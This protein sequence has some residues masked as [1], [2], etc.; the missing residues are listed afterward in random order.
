MPPADVTYSIADA[1][2]GPFSLNST[3]G[4]L[5]VTADLDYDSD[6]IPIFYSF[7]VNCSTSPNHTDTAVVEI[8]VEPV[9]DN[10]PALVST[11]SS[12][13]VQLIEDAPI[14][15]IIVVNNV[16]QGIPG[17]EIVDEDKGI[18]GVLT[19]LLSGG[20]G[21]FRIEPTTG[22]VFLQATIDVDTSTTG[23]LTFDMG[24]IACDLVS[25]MMPDTCPKVEVKVIG[26]PTNDHP[27]VFSQSV[28]DTFNVT[29]PEG[30]PI[31]API[32][33]VHCTDADRHTFGILQGIELWS[34]NT[35]IQQ[36]VR[37]DIN[38]STI[39]NATVILNATLDY[40]TMEAFNITLRCFDSGND[41]DFATVVVNI[42]P[43]NDNMPRFQSLHY[44]FSVDRINLPNRESI[45]TV[46]AIDLDKGHGGTLSYSLESSPY[47][48]ID[49]NG[50]ITLVDYI[51]AMEGDSFELFVEVSDGEFSDNATVTISVT[52]PLSVLDII[53]IEA[54][55]ICFI[56]L[57]CCFICCCCWCYSRYG[58]R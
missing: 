50:T 6:T 34:A 3:T 26:V 51:L 55:F 29:Y 24:I 9:N 48:E 11:P 8:S 38:D 44:N 2:P 46:E 32:A 12:V 58:K 31:N 45:G 7:T 33:E 40:E 42:E 18:D 37:V 47:F 53:I 17:Y 5:S 39:T 27:P 28:Y 54:G 21:Y 22:T 43:V 23:I 56:V 41:E 20:D 52:G 14:G 36:I 35:S 16:S 13:F 4:E 10:D 57:L 19:F 30:I 1:N 49:N 15:T 25:S